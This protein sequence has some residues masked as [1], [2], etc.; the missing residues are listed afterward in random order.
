MSFCP[1]C[2][3]QADNNARFCQVCGFRLE[4]SPQHISNQRQQYSAASQ[5]VREKQPD[6]MRQSD[7]KISSEEYIKNCLKHIST[8][9]SDVY[10]APYIQLKQRVNAAK[11]A[12]NIDPRHIVGM[13]DASVLT[14]GKDGLVFTTKNLYLPTAVISLENIE[15]ATHE[16]AATNNAYGEVMQREV[17]KVQYNNGQMIFIDARQTNLPLNVLAWFLNGIPSEVN[18]FES[19]NM[20]IDLNDLQEDTLCAYLKTVMAYILAD[21]N[22]TDENKYKAIVLFL[23]KYPGTK[24]RYQHLRYQ[25]FMQE[26]NDNYEKW[27]DELKIYMANESIW[28]SAVYHKLFEE[29][30]YI[31]EDRAKDWR[32]DDALVKIQRMLDIQES[33]IE[34]TLEKMQED[35]YSSEAEMKKLSAQIDLAYYT[36]NMIINDIYYLSSRLIDVEEKELDTN[37]YLIQ[38]I[39]KAGIV[40][41]QEMENVKQKYWSKMLPAMLNIVTFNELIDMNVYKMDYIK[42]VSQVFDEENQFQ[43]I[44]ECDASKLEAAYKVLSNIGY[45]NSASS[46][47]NQTKSVAKQG[48]SKLK[49][50]LFG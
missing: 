17:V 40:L 32:Q 46:T 34:K 45:F 1:N 3:T 24:E 50:S 37:C 14:N 18:C 21:K 25:R 29:L 48:F 9:R 5:E 49:N 44:V 8:M 2:G 36:N 41:E 11:M 19:L 12:K 47:M 43:L 23:A 30:L 33:W 10:I 38:T 27:I 15:R 31:H 6:I 42:A 20:P 7:Q 4:Q 28:A 22:E 26:D 35:A 13:I 39:S 16:W